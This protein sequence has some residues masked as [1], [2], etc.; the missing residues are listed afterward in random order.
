MS[1][2][3]ASVKR[4]VK[5][6]IDKVNSE[7]HSGFGLGSVNALDEYREWLHDETLHNGNQWIDWRS[8]NTILLLLDRLKD[9]EFINYNFRSQHVIVHCLGRDLLREILYNWERKTVAI[10]KMHE[11]KKALAELVSSE[12]E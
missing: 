3:D 12:Q 4:L 7:G 11:A 6:V 2:T 5:R 1:L 9:T 10:D 8:S